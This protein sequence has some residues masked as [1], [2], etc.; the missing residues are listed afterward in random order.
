L[1]LLAA[2]AA[3]PLILSRKEDAMAKG[4]KT[5]G[6]RAGTP[7]KRTE[8]RRTE[9]Q[10]NAAK[11]DGMKLG[12][13]WLRDTALLAAQMVEATRPLTADGKP[14]NTDRPHECLAWAKLLQSVAADI[15][16]YESPKLSAVA[17]APPAR[18]ER[19]MMTIRIFED[20][21]LVDEVVDGV[22]KMIEGKAVE[23]DDED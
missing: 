5:G 23:D 22:P 18:S 16:Q 11:R 21:K 7:N 13:D 4:K 14:T 12:L 2:A 15:T 8:A 20:D 17:I 19:T 9:A 1:F 6:R 10:Y 3:I